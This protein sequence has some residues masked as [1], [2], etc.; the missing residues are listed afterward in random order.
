MVY[1]HLYHWAPYQLFSRVFRDKITTNTLTKLRIL[2]L[3]V[4]QDPTS[5]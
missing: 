4:G 3:G 2:I 1:K 5:A